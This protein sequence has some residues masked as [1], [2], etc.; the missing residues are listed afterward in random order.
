VAVVTP[1]G[2]FNVIVEG[3]IVT[4][5]PGGGCCCFVVISFFFI[6]PCIVGVPG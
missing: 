2:Q 6:L 3:R 4:V 5:T 1:A